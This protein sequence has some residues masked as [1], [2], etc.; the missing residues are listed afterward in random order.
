M[1]GGSDILVLTLYPLSASFKLLLEK[2]L[3][4]R[5]HYRPVSELRHAGVVEFLRLVAT[6]RWRRIVIPYEVSEA[7]S[8]LSIVT[9]VAAAHRFPSVEI[10]DPEG[11]LRRVRPHEYAFACTG[12]A[13]ASLHGAWARVCSTMGARAALRRT[14]RRR[15]RAIVGRQRILYLKN[16]LWFG[17]RAGGSVGHVAG[18]ISGLVQL[19]HDVRFVSP[20]GPKFLRPEVESIRVPLFRHFALPPAVNWFRL[21][22]HAVDAALRAAEEFKPTLVYQRL[23][24]GD[25]SGVQI[26]DA[27]GIPLVVEYNGSELWIARN[28]GT[29]PRANAS[30]EPMEEA[31]LRRADLVFTVSQPLRDELVSRG[32]EAQRVAWYPN[33]VDTDQYDPDAVSE[34]GRSAAREHLGATS[35][36]FVIL[37]MGTFGDWHGAEVFA[38]AAALVADDREWMARQ[39]VRFAFVGDGKTRARCSEIVGMSQAADYTVFTGLVPQHEAP[40]YL[41]ASDAFIAS[42]VPNADG[43]KFF[44]SPT[45]LFEYMSMGRPI[46]ASALEQ[47]GEVL[48]DGRTAILVEPGSVPALAAG[49]R[50]VVENRGLGLRLG[51][52]ARIEAINKYTWG[53]HVGVMLAALARVTAVPDT[54][55]LVR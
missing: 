3:G 53:K 24:L 38:R 43:S 34:S 12:L 31:T 33:C 7:K 20:E 9:L 18:V 50:R 35:S 47:I 8:V 46:V 42:H 23:S 40:N 27:L 16:S 5:L 17:L 11:N 51:T 4:D 41:A 36:D 45:K 48:E 1:N 26:A 22:R 2:R 15:V 13:F 52:A 19:G 28:W 14:S 37:F 54:G 10:C 32:I 49:I 29:N 6:A 30:M 39:R 55:E 21:Q 25:W 44:G